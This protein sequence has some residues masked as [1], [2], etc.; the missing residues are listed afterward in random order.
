MIYAV[1]DTNVLVSALITHNV[2]AST[3]KV[4][5][6]IGDGKVIPL[7][8]DEIVAEYDEVLSREKFGL[9]KNR[10]KRLIEALK[11]KGINSE[12][13]ASGE[14]FPDVSDAV[15]Y[16]V[17]LSKENAYLVTGNLKHFPSTPIVVTPAE[18]I[19]ILGL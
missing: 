10:V 18:M 12:R 3:V 1:F 6:A 7:Y 13:V 16:E 5:E 2:N 17:A 19:E 4:V 8:N 9:L 11:N 15:F 14:A